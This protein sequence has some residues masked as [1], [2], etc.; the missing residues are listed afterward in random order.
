M[1]R[2]LRVTRGQW[3]TSTGRGLK[4]LRH[5]IGG[6]KT[7][8][9]SNTFGGRLALHRIKRTGSSNHG[10]KAGG[11]PLPEHGRVIG[12]PDVSRELHPPG[13]PADFWQPEPWLPLPGR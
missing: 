1:L 11:T 10:L 9:A 5:R 6:F 7:C 3:R 8:S 13:P 4:D 12:L 2:I